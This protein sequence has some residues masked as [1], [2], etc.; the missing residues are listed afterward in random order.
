[1][2]II[3][4]A[5]NHAYSALC[6]SHLTKVGHIKWDGACKIASLDNVGVA[7]KKTKKRKLD[8]F[9][10]MGRS[11]WNMRDTG[12]FIIR[13]G[14]AELRTHRC[15]PAAAAPSFAA[16]LSG[17]M[18]AAKTSKLTIEDADVSDVEAFLKF[19]YTGDLGKSSNYCA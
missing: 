17:E 13:C 12:D 7:R 19:L 5:E 10:H 8:H 14:D 6:P 15:I 3:R 1:M 2:G 9:E 11:L 4:D 18:L 16:M